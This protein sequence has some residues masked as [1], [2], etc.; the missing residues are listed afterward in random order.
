MN[1]DAV[2]IE[3]LNMRGM[4]QTLHFGKSVMDLGWGMFTQ[5][6]EYEC[7]K[8]GTLLIKADKWFASSK[9]CN[10]C[11]HVNKDLSLSDRE[12]VCTE[13]G[14]IADRDRNAA[15]NLMD[16]AK[17]VINPVGTSGLDDRGVLGEIEETLLFTMPENELAEMQVCSKTEGK[18]AAKSL[19]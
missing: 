2:C 6:L 18:E 16:Y 14:C 19:A 7:S 15:L 1:Y 8:Y 3:D 4:S 9:T 17:E 5:W 12:W 11:G 10:H 13:C